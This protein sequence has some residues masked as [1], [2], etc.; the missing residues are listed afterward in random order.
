MPDKNHP[1]PVI[2]VGVLVW[3]EKRLLLGKR[4]SKDHAPCW[5]FPGGHLEDGESVT[6]C[7]YREVQEETG[8]KI[9]ALRHL[10]FT[11]KS[12]AVGQRQYVTLLVSGIYVS[13]EAQTLELDKCEVWQWFDY[14]QLPQPLFEPISLFMS[15]QDDLYALHRTSQVLPDTPSNVRK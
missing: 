3:R 1:P 6:E 10:G 5:Q 13:G 11:D 15:Q 4:I 12:F 9:K 2:G 8:L 7:A 14:R